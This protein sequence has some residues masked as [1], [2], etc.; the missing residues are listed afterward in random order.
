MRNVVQS[1][2][3]PRPEVVSPSRKD[4]TISTIECPTS[5]SYEDWEAEQAEL[6][7]TA[8]AG[9]LPGRTREA[10]CDLVW[11]L[12]QSS[13]QDATQRF[14]AAHAAQELAH[15]GMSFDEQARRANVD[16]LTI[17]GLF[18]QAKADA[19]PTLE[20]ERLV[21]SDDWDGTLESVMETSGFGQATARYL[22]ARIGVKTKAAEQVAAGG[23]LKYGPEVY[24]R[25]KHLRTVEGRSYGW[26]G[27]EMGMNR[28]TVARMCLR[29][30]WSLP[31]EGD[32][33]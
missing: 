10:L 5:T 8:W 30:G 20:A 26:I 4:R 6:G 19:V 21:R 17:A 25:I 15:D 2:L 18:A 14:S 13:T 16:P 9:A 3:S 32:D 22:L 29:R 11:H 1:E 33:Q 7:Y 12:E 31:T 28:T 23:G 24:E 27:K